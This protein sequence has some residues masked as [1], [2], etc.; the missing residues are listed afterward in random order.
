MPEEHRIPSPHTGHH[1]SPWPPCGP[2][3][4]AE[5]DFLAAAGS[6]Y[7]Y[8]DNWLDSNYWRELGSRLGSGQHY[9]DYTG[10]IAGCLICSVHM[11]R[12]QLSLALCK[13]DASQLDANQQQQLTCRHG[14]SHP[15]LPGIGAALYT[16]SHLQ[17]ATQLLQQLSLG[18]PHSKSPS[19][20]RT[21][22]RVEAARQLVLEWF[23]ADPKDYV[24]VWTK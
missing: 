3:A 2:L 10:V 13:H 1:E 4:V 8:H 15:C 7:G 14:C 11:C 22:R 19:S 6:R 5:A 9:I 18:N 21:S 24:V 20:E 17:A 16:S 12:C 23:G